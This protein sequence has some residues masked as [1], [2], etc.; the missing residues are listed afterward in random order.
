MN[1]LNYKKITAILFIA[2]LALVTVFSL[3]TKDKEFSAAE[4]RVLKSRPSFSLGKYVEGRFESE[5]EEYANDQFPART[6]FVRLKTAT[7]VAEGKLEASGIYRC[8]DRYLMEDIT[9]P[10]DH[11]EPTRNALK[12]FKRNYSEVD[13]YFLLA[14][15]AANILE[16]KLPASVR[17]YDQNG[18]MDDF[19]A[20][21][22]SF[23]YKPVDV[24][25][26]FRKNKD[27][28]QLYYRTDHHWTTKGAHLAFKDAVK[29]MGLKDKVKYK[30][31]AVKNDFRGTLYSRSG[32]TNGMDDTIEIFM[33]T[34]NKEYKN[35]V[36]Y[37]TDTKK[38]TTKFYQLKNLNKKDAYTVFGGSNHPLYTIT[39]P[40][41]SQEN[42]LLIKDSYA[43][44]IIPFLAQCYRKIVVVDPRYF[45]GDVDEIIQSHGVDDILFVYNGNTFFQDDSLEMMLTD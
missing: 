30:G 23:G 45:F 41:E 3:V 21:L 33:P 15:N 29:V 43:N 27:K 22:K 17:T 18:A 28:T 31:Y 4:N 1:D 19:F 39:T 16:D 25:K 40:C 7:D 14:P 20:D 9:V 10:G 24:R 13:M 11:F 42:L 5:Y 32:F 8:R 37:Y 2:M 36:I 35:S 12:Q 38:K 44:S 26:T 6:G 34:N